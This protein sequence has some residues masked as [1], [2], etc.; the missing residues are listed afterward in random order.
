MESLPELDGEGA[1]AERSAGGAG[2]TRL[3]CQQRRDPA[4]KRSTGRLDGGVGF[5]PQ[6]RQSVDARVSPEHCVG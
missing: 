1:R 6:G 5:L 2:D 4:K 3:R